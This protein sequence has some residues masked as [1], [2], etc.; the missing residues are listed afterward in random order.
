MRKVKEGRKEGR[1]EEREAEGR[2][3]G[4]GRER[5][6]FDCCNP[7][8]RKESLKNIQTRS[9]CKLSRL[10]EAVRKRKGTRRVGRVKV[11]G[12][13]EVRGEESGKRERGAFL[14]ASTVSQHCEPKI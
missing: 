3:R 11:E 10:R 9:S 12:I 2:Q 5:R 8:R 1:E 4:R 6:Y 13:T 7:L 14:W